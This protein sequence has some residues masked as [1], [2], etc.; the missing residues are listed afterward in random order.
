MAAGMPATAVDRVADRAEALALLLATG[1][2]TDTILLKAS[3]GVALDELVEPLVRAG[4]RRETPGMTRHQRDVGG[5]LV[6]GC[7][8]AFFAGRVVDAQRSS[9]PSGGWGWAS[10]SGSMARESHYSKEGTPTM[11]GLLIILVVI[12]VSL[13]MEGVPQ[14]QRVRQQFIDPGTFA[15]LATLALRGGLGAVDDWLNARTGDGIRAR[16]KL[17]LADRR[18]ARRRLAD[19]G[20]PTT[21]R[22]SWCR[23]SGQSVSTPGCTSCSGPSPSW[24]PATR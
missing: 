12:A 8:A 16:H 15:P 23:S 7:L 6:I 13:V 14:P 11:G 9:G 22:P 24:P 3:R 5:L 1:R 18:G 20:R 17:D 4:G 19:P 21:S 2:P 10:A